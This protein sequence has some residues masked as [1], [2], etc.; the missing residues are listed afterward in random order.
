[1]VSSSH[2]SDLIK[3][4]TSL[5]LTMKIT[6]PAIRAAAL[7]FGQLLDPR[8][9]DTFTYRRYFRSL[10]GCNVTHVRYLWNTID[11]EIMELRFDHIGWLLASLY[12]LRCYPTFDELSV[13]LGKNQ[14]TVRKHVWRFVD[15]LAT[16]DL[17]RRRSGGLYPW[18]TW[19]DPANIVQIAIRKRISNIRRISAVVDQHHEHERHHR[20]DPVPYEPL[21]QPAIV[22][23]D[24]DNHLSLTQDQVG[25]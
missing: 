5:I 21:T 8:E 24:H 11:S 3:V 2:K 15:Y 20:P 25:E 6:F 23:D 12:F 14:V 16:L 10:F 1:M 22:D 18:L 9:H 17:V 7:Q 4:S 19:T 13:K